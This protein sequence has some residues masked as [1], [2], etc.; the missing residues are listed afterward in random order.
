MTRALCPPWPEKPAD[1]LIIKLRF[2]HQGWPPPVPPKWY[3]ETRTVRAAK[4]PESDE[5]GITGKIRIP[6][7]IKRKPWDRWNYETYGMIEFERVSVWLKL[8]PD[9]K[10]ANVAV[11]FETS[12]L[13]GKEEWD[14]PLHTMYQTDDTIDFPPIQEL[15]NYY[16]DLTPD[17]EH[18]SWCRMEIKIAPP[19]TLESWRKSHPPERREK[20]A[21][22]PGLVLN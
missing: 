1:N 10:T 22:G 5:W 3:W 17:K 21:V 20:T 8:L 16:W 12:G 14:P 7:R 6:R 15:Q 13:V 19:P 4:Y 9:G 2:D 18:D 11:K